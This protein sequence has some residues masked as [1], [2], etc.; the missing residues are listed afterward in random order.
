METSADSIARHRNLSEYVNDE[1]VTAVVIAAAAGFVLGG[2]VNR[3][4]GLAMLTLL[5]RIAFRS[6]AANLIFEAVSGGHSSGQDSGARHGS[7][8]HDNGRTNL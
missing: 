5:G 1:P 3:R 4:I 2:G 6:V 8:T 7:G